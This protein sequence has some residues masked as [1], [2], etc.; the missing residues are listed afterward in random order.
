MGAVFGYE[1]G[2][3]AFETLAKGVEFPNAVRLG[4]FAKKNRLLETRV[5]RQFETE[6]FFVRI[7]F[8]EPNIS[9]VDHSEVLTALSR[10]MNRDDEE[11]FYDVVRDFREVDGETA[12]DAQ[13]TTRLVRGAIS[14]SSRCLFVALFIFCATTM[15]IVVLLKKMSISVER[16]TRK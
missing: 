13:E 12:R 14:D 5:F 9:V 10:F 3:I 4:K 1:R 8:D 11:E 2:Q 15:T 16:P 7:V 6:N